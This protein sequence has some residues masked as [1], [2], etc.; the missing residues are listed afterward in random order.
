MAPERV[1]HMTR[2]E[3]L[4]Q[5]TGVELAAEEI[6]RLIERRPTATADEALLLVRGRAEVLGFGL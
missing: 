3:R 6:E 5:Q 2:L 1:A 4:A